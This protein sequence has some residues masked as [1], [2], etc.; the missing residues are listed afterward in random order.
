[1]ALPSPVPS[2]LGVSNFIPSL[3]DDVALNILARIPRCYHV[4]LSA[5]SKPIRALLSSP[6][7][8]DARSQLN[9]T[10]NQFYLWLGPLFRKRRSSWFVIQRSPKPNSTSRRNFCLVP[11]PPIPVPTLTNFALAS[12]GHQIYVIGGMEGKGQARAPTSL[13]CMLDCRFHTWERVSDMGTARYSAEAVVADGKIY[14]TEG[15]TWKDWAKANWAE[16]F[17]PSVGRWEALPSPM[18]VST[19]FTEVFPVML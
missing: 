6:D 7:F 2:V 11:V 19:R 15:V 1:M 16:V 5:V 18:T 12:L 17:D 9:Y 13:V 4:V 14:V 10:E 8:F 3:P